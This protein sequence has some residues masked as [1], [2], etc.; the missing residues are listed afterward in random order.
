MASGIDASSM[1]IWNVSSISPTA[2]WSTAF[3]SSSAWRVVQRTSLSNRFSGSTAR[4]IPPEAACAPACFGRDRPRSEEHTSELQSH[5][6]LVCR[7]LLEKKKKNVYSFWWILHDESLTLN[8]TGGIAGP[9]RTATLAGR[10]ST[11]ALPS[12][13]GYRVRI[14]GYGRFVKR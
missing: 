7:L 11:G 9:D 5:L 1:C 13:D 10:H 6:N 14:S 4:T 8:A 2:G 12:A 3:S